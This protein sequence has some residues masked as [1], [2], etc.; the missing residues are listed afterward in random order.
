MTTKHCDVY[1]AKRVCPICSGLTNYR[2]FDLHY[3][4]F[5]DSPLSK[6]THVAACCQCGFVYNDTS[7]SENDF[8]EFYS[9]HYLINA[10]NSSSCDYQSNENYLE[11]IS[12]FLLEGGVKRDS[13]IADM[14]CGH[15]QLLRALAKEGFVDL[16]GI[17][18]CAEYIAQ[19]NEDGFQVRL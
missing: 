4:L 11:G 17:E 15:G 18:L 7:S 1:S 16:E 19:L 14:G 9:H 6:L 10:Y 5:D 3:I 8:N 2:L 13:Q 12:T